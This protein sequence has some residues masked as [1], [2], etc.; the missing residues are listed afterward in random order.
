MSAAVQSA[1]AVPPAGSP[2]S[3]AA[4]QLIDQRIEEARRALWWSEL[5]RTGL[6]VAIGTMLA[7][8]VWL[9]MDHWF[10]SPGPLVRVICFVAL[11]VT[12]TR[13]FI[14][15][16]WPVMTSSVTPEYAAWALEQDHADY[17]EQLTSY[18]TLKHDG[19]QRGV[20]SRVVRVIGARAAS[21]LKAHDS[22]PNEATG[23]FR[24]WI[25]A[26]IV[27]ALLAAYCVGSPKSSLASAKRLVAPLASIDPAKRVQIS[28]VQPGDAEAIAG[29]DLQVSAKVDG[30]RDDE[31]V[32][33]RWLTDGPGHQSQLALDP[34]SGRFAGTIAIDHS[35][36]GAVRYTIQAGDAVAGPFLLNV[37][38]VPVVAI[39]SVFYQPPA[40]TLLKARTTSSPAISAIDGTKVRINAKTN[41][42]VARAE[43]Q[44]NSKPVGETVKVTGGRTPITIAD[45]GMTLTADVT[46]RSAIGKTASVELENYRIRV[47]DSNEQPNPDPIVYPIKVVADL[48]PEV[49]IVVPKKSPVKVPLNAQQTIEVHAMDADFELQQV[50]L[51][52]ERGINTLEEPLIWTKPVGGSGRGN[53]VAEY[54]FRPLEHLL[55]PG[56]VVRISATARD[57]RSIPDDP[58]V[59]PNEATTDQIE[60]QITENDQQVPEDATENDGLSRPDDRPASDTQQSK[61]GASGQQSSGG[62]SSTGGEG[63]Q[64]QGTQN[65]NSGGQGSGSQTADQQDSDNQQNSD[66]HSGGSRESGGNPSDTDQSTPNQN[67]GQTGQQD[68]TTPNAGNDKTENNNA[69]SNDAGSNDKGQSPANKSTSNQS[70]ENQSSENQSTENQ[71]TGDSMNQPSDSGAESSSDNPTSAN[72]KGQDQSGKPAGGQSRQNEPNQQEDPSAE[73]NPGDSESSSGGDAATDANGQNATGRQNSDGDKTGS[74]KSQQADAEKN[75]AG[76]N[77][78][79]SQNGDGSQQDSN[80]D[81]SQSAPKHDGEAI[82]RMKDYIEKQKQN[83]NQG[84]RSNQ[85]PNQEQQRSNESTTDNSDSGAEKGSQA[86][87]EQTGASDQQ[88]TGDQSSSEKGA[89]SGDPQT[90]QSRSKDDSSA[91]GGTDSKADTGNDDSKSERAGQRDPKNERNDSSSGGS[92][93]QQTP[94][95]QSG[96]PNENSKDPNSTQN[97]PGDASNTPPGSDSPANQNASQGQPRS[98]KSSSGGA[99]NGSGQA[100]QDGDSAAEPPPPPDLEYAKKATDMV[101][102]YL[103]ETRDQVDDGLLKELNWTEQDLQ[104]FRERWEKVRQMEQPGGDASSGNDFQDALQS[105]GLQPNHTPNK[106]TPRTADDLRNLRDSGNRR[107]APP[108]IRDAFDAFRRR[109]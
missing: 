105:L 56:D 36:Y 40:Y 52:I 98:P 71:S 34:S 50:T 80:T 1:A 88:P 44:F 18:V 47:W 43:L 78:N 67:K 84:E 69:G 72:N 104:R 8:L 48:P 10:Y 60:L 54:R 70:S 23:T 96:Q 83:Q 15:R 12:A 97:Q 76:Q 20:R 95:D 19:G 106:S 57:N 26:A 82:E 17:R 32:L 92:P 85:S 28:D 66:Q 53:H 81:S 31:P 24:W 65:Q 108:A 74:S 41:R 11:L 100:P 3:S 38:N 22:L 6:R 89:D 107:K 5:T 21:L 68:G 91:D 61:D 14:R 55:R 16:A 42:P 27:F 13:F 25:T 64:S 29:R 51:R 49:A 4:D 77:N 93:S 58:K 99:G 30:L 109:Q 63:A 45:D 90:G 87:D 102:D 94:G 59:K 33:C 86:T 46:L 7:L 39:E 37:E 62:G 2:H 101:L 9:V 103:D 73:Q 35:T 75:N 79:P